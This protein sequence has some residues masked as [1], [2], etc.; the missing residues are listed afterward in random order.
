MV[1]PDASGP[2][3]WPQESHRK[4]QVRAISLRWGL[5]RPR[6]SRGSASWPPSAP[7]HRG[8]QDSTLHGRV[9]ARTECAQARSATFSRS[10]GLRL[11]HRKGASNWESRSYGEEERRR[12]D[13]AW[14][15]AHG[16]NA[17]TPAGNHHKTTTIRACRAGVAGALSQCQ[18]SA[19]V[20][21]GDWIRTSD[22]ANPIHG[23][24]RGA[25]SMEGHKSQ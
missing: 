2:K 1:L 4:R 5:C 15:V 24:G 18:T 6:T 11:P 3:P 12:A 10:A 23:C 14:N 16:R 8:R 21:R 19:Y 17:G 20:G 22:L 13:V 7:R 25:A 9:S